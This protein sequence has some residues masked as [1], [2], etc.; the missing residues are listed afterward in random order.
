MIEAAY[1]D[2]PTVV[3]LLVKSFDVNKSV[4]HIIKQDHKR[5]KR[6]GGLME[7]SFEVCHQSGKI[8]L[9]DNKKGCALVVLPDQRKITVASILLDIKLIT[10]SV[11][12]SNVKRALVRE[13]KIQKVHSNVLMSY[14][15]FIGVEPGQ[16]NKGTGSRLLREVIRECDAQNRPIY[17][18]T[19]TLENIPWYE[20]FGFKIY[21]E[22][23]LGYTLYFMKRE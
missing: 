1:T 18:E 23:D 9:S 20:K 19:S 4:N 14:L 11:G 22:L 7:Y 13:S 12:F 21:H 6:L 3:E 5:I 16:Q 2:K 8:F 10:T 15:W 17:L